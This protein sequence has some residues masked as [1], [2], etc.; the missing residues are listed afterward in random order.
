MNTKQAEHN[1]KWQKRCK[2]ITEAQKTTTYH[3][4]NPKLCKNNQNSP[5]KHKMLQNEWKEAQINYKIYQ[6]LNIDT[7]QPDFNFNVFHKS[8]T[9][10]QGAV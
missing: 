2:T 9:Q 5:N 1:F 8:W 7:K 6:T 4:N 10:A 3:Q